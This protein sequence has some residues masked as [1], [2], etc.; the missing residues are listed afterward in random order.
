MACTRTFGIAEIGNEFAGA[1]GHI[2]HSFRII[3]DKDTVIGINRT[4]FG[5]D[6]AIRTVACR[7]IRK[8]S[9]ILEMLPVIVAAVI[10]MRLLAT[11]HRGSQCFQR[12]IDPASCQR[13]PFDLPSVR[14]FQLVQQPG[15]MADYGR[16]GNTE[17]A[18]LVGRTELIPVT[19]P[20]GNIP[21][22]KIII[23]RILLVDID[24]ITRRKVN[25]LCFLVDYLADLCLL[26]TA[27]IIKH[28]RDSVT[29]LAC[30]HFYNMQTG[31]F[32]QTFLLGGRGS[33]VCLYFE[34]DARFIRFHQYAERGVFGNIF[35]DG[36]DFEIA[37]GLFDDLQTSQFIRISGA[38]RFFPECQLHLT[39][40]LQGRRKRNIEIRHIGST[41]ED[42]SL[43]ERLSIKFE[44]PHRPATGCE[45]TA[46]PVVVVVR[47]LGKFGKWYGANHLLVLCQARSFHPTFA[48]EM[49]SANTQESASHIF[50]QYECLRHRLVFSR[51]F[52]DRHVE[53]RIRLIIDIVSRPSRFLVEQFDLDSEIAILGNS[54]ILFLHD[55]QRNRQ[56]T[57]FQQLTGNTVIGM[58]L[59]IIVFAF[60]IKRITILF[61]DHRIQVVVNI[62]LRPTEHFFTSALKRGRHLHS[63]DHAQEFPCRDSG[64]PEGNDFEML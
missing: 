55:R 35:G 21:F 45:V 30:T 51:T 25:L 48:A 20:V 26:R 8:D 19:D 24:F 47:F 52:R 63:S 1:V 32:K 15:V 16:V 18:P 39:T 10:L 40:A 3:M 14:D 17:T 27:T 61:T 41:V 7:H 37:C 58:A 5:K 46:D 6:S 62:K 2:R 28:Q 38:M 9:L 11:E 49:R 50:R 56:F 57:R 12:R 22:K 42:V 4:M 33:T 43:E 29:G 34:A 23:R 54:Q 64:L 36:N 44:L 31:L 13:T 53:H 60:E 59:E